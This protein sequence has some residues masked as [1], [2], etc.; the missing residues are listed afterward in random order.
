MACSDPAQD[1]WLFV[2][3][4]LKMKTVG[5]SAGAKGRSG[6]HQ[7]DNIQLISEVQA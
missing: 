6:V 2:W 1:C 5:L 7:S 4:F 3:V